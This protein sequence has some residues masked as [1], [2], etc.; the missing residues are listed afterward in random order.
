VR[1]HGEAGG[2]AETPSGRQQAPVPKAQIFRNRDG[3]TD[4]A[5]Q[6]TISQ[7]PVAKWVLA[8]RVA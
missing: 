5:G 8:G 4:A 3:G 2:G 6:E 7:L 1:A